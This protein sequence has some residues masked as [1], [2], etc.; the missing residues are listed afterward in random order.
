ME[1]DKDDINGGDLDLFMH[2]TMYMAETLDTIDANG[3]TTVI[4]S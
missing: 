1:T 3:F 4:S 2:F